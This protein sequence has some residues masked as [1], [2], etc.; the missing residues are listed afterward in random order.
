MKTEHIKLEKGPQQRFLSRATQ[1]Q[2]VWPCSQRE[3]AELIR[4]TWGC[5]DSSLPEPQP[6]IPRVPPSH[7]ATSPSLTSFSEELAEENLTGIKGA[8][9]GSQQGIETA[10][11][12][13]WGV[14]SRPF[15]YRASCC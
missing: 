9:C 10:A 7:R 15:M 2:Q 5:T 14:S 6:S 8:L 11:L 4:R 12:G 13:G 3:A 1:T